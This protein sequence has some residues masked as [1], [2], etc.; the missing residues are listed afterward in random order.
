MNY[1]IC[2]YGALEE[3]QSYYQT[4]CIKYGYAN[5]IET[6]LKEQLF[7]N[8]TTFLFENETSNYQSFYIV[9]KMCRALVQLHNTLKECLY[10]KRIFFQDSDDYYQRK[11]PYLYPMDGQWGIVSERVANA[12]V[13]NEVDDQ[14][15]LIAERLSNMRNRK[16]F[17]QFE[18]EWHQQ[19]LYNKILM[20]E[21]IRVEE[22]SVT[23]VKQIVIEKSVCMLYLKEWKREDIFDCFIEY[24][25]KEGR[26][27]L[28]TPAVIN[29][30]QCLIQ[31]EEL[32]SNQMNQL[33]RAQKSSE[34]G[35][36]K[37]LNIGERTRLKR[38]RTALEKLYNEQTVNPNLK[39][40]LMN[41][42]KGIQNVTNNDPGKY[43]KYLS[44][45]GENS[46]QKEAFLHAIGSSDLYLIQGP[47]G[48]GKTTV[49]TEL[50]NYIVD[51][52]QKVLI[53]SETHI[54]V[55]NVLERIQ[56]RDNFFPIRLGN[57]EIVTPVNRDYLIDRSVE[58]LLRNT[59]EKGRQQD[60]D[61]QNPQEAESTIRIRLND[62]ICKIEEKIT[63]TK[64]R[65]GLN[66][67]SKFDLKRIASYQEKVS[68]CAELY[69]H[70]R[71]LASEYDNW[72]RKVEEVQL[73]IHEYE[74]SI[75][76]G[77][78]AKDNYGAS[79]KS[80]MDSFRV[81]EEEA[82]INIS[83]MKL[84]LQK[85]NEDSIEKQY[86]KLKQEFLV[87]KEELER[88]RLFVERKRTKK[89]I[90][91]KEYVYQIQNGICDILDMENKK[92]M[93]KDQFELDM[94]EEIKKYEYR[95][96]LLEKTRDIR[97][98]WFEKT[99]TA[100]VNAYFQDLYI[101]MA[102]VI[103]ATCS[104]ITATTNRRFQEMS[105]DY[106]IVDE[107]AKCN[108]LDLLIPLTMG[109]KIILLGD[110]KQLAPMIDDSRL[111]DKLDE[112]VIES[113]RENTLFKK[114]YEERVSESCKCMLDTQYRMDDLICKFISNTFYESKL[115]NGCGKRNHGIKELSS[116]MLWL[117]CPRSKE[118]LVG[119][120]YR[121]DVE[122]ELIVKFLDFLDKKS[123][124]K[125]TVGIISP[126]RRQ[127]DRISE[128]LKERAYLNLDV[129]N[130]TIDAFQGK[131]KQI[132]IFGLVRSQRISGFLKDANRLNVAI[133]RAQE[134][135]AVVGDVNMVSQKNAGLLANLHQ[136]MA[137]H[138]C[139]Y[140]ENLCNL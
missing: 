24:T 138:G 87:K 56:H 74:L 124:S 49:I 2:S 112:S 27:A 17:L 127:V 8:G 114:L 131:E 28:G 78:E 103:C 68:S 100:G 80:F 31:F 115:I 135:C 25:W 116:T 111:K 63:E 106:V 71:K 118:I 61:Y 9:G 4:E 93:C 11:L 43:R 72:K 132:I 92:K 121:N 23:K 137:T 12:G 14:R 91:L 70:L 35:T 46:M 54:A 108:T 94:K 85:L 58:N 97:K 102:N 7:I 10:I 76:I 37:I 51:H 117:D 1:I 75:R 36:I 125:K 57:E 67:F 53:S 104:G 45:F 29:Q 13:I 84:C 98:D 134:L 26:I 101:D 30:D 99:E 69:E 82:R 16:D 66:S 41:Q 133:S 119:T 96:H 120:S 3:V 136:Y 52:D 86:L 109:K 39:V 38:Q 77:K 55:D 33:L 21:S 83:K 65:L 62:A 15:V 42:M 32:E 20:E 22:E 107:A 140:N 113:I 90:S 139:I 129:E 34:A 18:E 105:Y 50:V 88:D 110:H 73:K 6:Y 40:L 64:V 44:R 19:D 5:S 89:E 130:S 59:R 79:A 128:L 123:V 48:T 95:K 126:Y 47:P 60:Q 81:K 122:A